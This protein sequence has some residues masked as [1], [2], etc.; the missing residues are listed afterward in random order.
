MGNGKKYCGKVSKIEIPESSSLSLKFTS[1]LTGRSKISCM[2]GAFEP[3]PSPWKLFGEFCY[4]SSNLQDQRN[5]TYA[6][7]G[8]QNISAELVSIH[9]LE[10]NDFVNATVPEFRMAYWI[11]LSNVTNVVK[12]T[13]GTPVDYIGTLS[14]LPQSTAICGEISEGEW[15]YNFCSNDKSYVCKKKRGSSPMSQRG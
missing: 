5:W 8:C 1:K 2:V 9:S 14:S 12:W 6:A 11:G 13:D 3:C 4:W 7:A 10:E 15:G